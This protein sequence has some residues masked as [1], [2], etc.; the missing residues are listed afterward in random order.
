MAEIDQIAPIKFGWRVRALRQSPEWKMG[1]L[2]DGQ[3][4]DKSPIGL[5]SLS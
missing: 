2:P 4:T 5:S 3:I 1:D